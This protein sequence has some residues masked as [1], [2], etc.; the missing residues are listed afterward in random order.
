MRQALKRA[1]SSAGYEIRRLPQVRSQ[2]I[3]HSLLLTTATY[4]PWLRDEA[5]QRAHGLIKDHTMVD[6]Y[7]CY[8]LWQLVGESAKLSGDLLEV[9]VW[10]GGTGCLMALRCKEAG[11]RGEVHL[12]DT[13]EGVANAG[14]QDTAYR[15][16]EHADTSVQIVEDLASACNLDNVRLWKGIFPEQNGAALADR[17]FRFCHIDVDV[18]QSACNVLEWVWGR[19]APGGIVVFDDYGFAGCEGVTRLVNEQ[20][21]RPDRVMIYNLNGHAILVK[22]GN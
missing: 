22:L 5:F 16:G 13:F 7:R 14:A 19:L 9:G 8:E 21:A 17:S 20:R 3:G 2:D 15:G 18:Y 11:I 12:C 4:S 6:L 1:L 10:R